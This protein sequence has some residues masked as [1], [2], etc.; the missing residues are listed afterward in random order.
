[1]IQSGVGVS[2]H[3]GSWLGDAPVM[4]TFAGKAAVHGIAEMGQYL[5]FDLACDVIGKAEFNETWLPSTN[6]P[7]IL[8]AV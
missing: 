6:R 1:M 7:E 4:D 2:H 3:V 5:V 8:N